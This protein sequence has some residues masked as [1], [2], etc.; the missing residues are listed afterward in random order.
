M[1]SKMNARGGD[2]ACPVCFV[3]FEK[4]LRVVISCNHVLC[5]KCFIHLMKRECPICRYEFE[6]DLPRLRRN[7]QKNLIEYLSTAPFD[8][9]R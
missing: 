2:D 7:T 5:M 3:G 9:E 1:L 4:R 6:T 8:D